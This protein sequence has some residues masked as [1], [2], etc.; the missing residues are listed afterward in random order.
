MGVLLEKVL[1]GPCNP[2]GGAAAGLQNRTIACSPLGAHMVFSLL[3]SAVILGV[4]ASFYLTSVQLSLFPR[5]CSGR[6]LLL[7]LSMNVAVESRKIP[8]F[9]A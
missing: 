1:R 8:R 5:P 2:K 6:W 9:L 4:F 3:F 7:L